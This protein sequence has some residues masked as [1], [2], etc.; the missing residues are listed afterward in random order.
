MSTEVWVWV[1]S[2]FTLAILSFLYKDNPFFRFAES[3]FAG[4]SMGYYI[5]LTFKNTFV[6]NL[7]A[8]LFHI[9]PAYDPVTYPGRSAEHWLLIVPFVLAIVLYTRYVQK[10][11]W[12]SRF[13]LAVYVGYYTGLNMMQKLQGEVLPQS[14]D[15]IRSFWRFLPERLPI[16]AA[17][18]THTVNWGEWVSSVVF[19]IGVL[20]VLVYFFFSAEHKGAVGAVSR[21]G[22]W[23][24]M[25]SFGAAFGYTIM[26]R[27][28][29][30]IGRVIFLVGDWL[31][32]G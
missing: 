4:I 28:S 5:N 8:P 17:E 10:I 31:G 13:A 32:F 16:W 24:L 15:T 20:A 9:G 6:P 3:A 12:V 23:F 11:A 2:L 1:A 30:L 29:I 21:L 22:I 25:V 14:A 18:Q 26:G 27:V 7:F 19:V